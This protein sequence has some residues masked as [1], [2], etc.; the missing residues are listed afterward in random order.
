MAKPEGD[1][2][3]ILSSGRWKEAVQAYLATIAFCDSQVGRLLD[4]LDQS[5]YR[6]NTIVCLWSD[7]GWS[8]GEKEHWRKFALWEE[9]TRTVFIWKVPGLTPAGVQSPRPVD[10]MSIYPTLCSLTRVKTPAH[11]EGLDITPL[12]K[13]PDAAWDIPALTTFHKDN[14]SFRGEQW[15]YIRYADG[16]EELYDHQADPNEWTNVVNDP[17]YSTIKAEFAK[18][19]P[20]VNVPELPRSNEQSRSPQTKK[21][22][23]GK[24]NNK[25]KAKAK[26]KNNE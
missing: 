19:I 23:K 5:A 9:P 20:A 2:A 7:H 15:R 1:H 8:L 4:A 6:D 16:S 26:A 10:L 24:G 13:N 12:L 21:N 25:A 11:V 14:H 3:A 18:H 17:K 22:A